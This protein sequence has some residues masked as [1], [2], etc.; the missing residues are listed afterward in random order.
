M[1]MASITRP[2][3]W[4]TPFIQ[5]PVFGNKLP[6]EAPIN[7]SGT[8]MPSPSANKPSPPNNTSW[9]CPMYISAPAS[10]AA[11]HGLTIRA[12]KAPMTNTPIK[13]PPFILLVVCSI[14]SSKR[15]GSFNSYRPNM[16]PASNTN[17]TAVLPKTQGFCKA[18]LIKL[19]VRP[20]ATPAKA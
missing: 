12:D 9:V 7:S 16:E 10:G 3:K 6:A 15:C 11:T 18:W 13:R 14:W 20:A 17:N 5:S 19:P 2:K 1:A 8:P 4:R